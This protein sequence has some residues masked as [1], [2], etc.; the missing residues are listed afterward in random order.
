MQAFHPMLSWSLDSGNPCRR[1]NRSPYLGPLEKGSILTSS[2]QTEGLSFRDQFLVPQITARLFAITTTLPPFLF[3]FFFFPCHACQGKRKRETKYFR[4]R[5]TNIS[6]FCCCF[7]TATKTDMT[8]K[9]H[10]MLLDCRSE[11]PEDV[12]LSDSNLVIVVTNSNVKHKLAGSQVRLVL[13]DRSVGR[14]VGWSADRYVYR[15][16]GRYHR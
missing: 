13:V 15:S 10:A 16:V 7:C 14:S 8:R 9:G 3:L 5:E 4:K 6:V 1:D 12:P 2:F 11:K